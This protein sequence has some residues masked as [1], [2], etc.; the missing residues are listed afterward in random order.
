M[1]RPTDTPDGLLAWIVATHP[2][3]AA[4][5]LTGFVSGI[6]LLFPGIDIAVAGLFHV[7]GVDPETPFPAEHWRALLELRWAGM[8][9]TRWATILIVLALLAKIVTPM[10][11]RAVPMRELLF[12]A[13]SLALGPGLLVNAFFKEVWGRPRPI[14]TTIFGGPWPFMPAWIPG[15]ACPGNCSFPSG[16]ASGAA[17]LLALVVVAPERW[18]KPLL[19]V[20]LGWMV[21][22]SANRVV[23]GSHFLSDVLIGWCL[24]LVVIAVMREL[25]LVRLPDRFVAAADT[26]LA[27]LGEALTAPFRPRP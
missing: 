7:P 9:V 22:I 26:G 17:W 1:T 5:A 25:I 21:A 4:L 16:E 8:A 19:A 23:F 18:R 2:I 24:M 11:A 13:G 15:G 20:V 10:L 27:R 14:E 3:L 6:A 12:L